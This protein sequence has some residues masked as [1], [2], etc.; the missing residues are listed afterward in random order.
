MALDIVGF[1]WGLTGSHYPESLVET[2]QHLAR[3]GYK[4]SSDQPLER[5]VTTMANEMLQVNDNKT[6]DV[7]AKK[8]SSSEADL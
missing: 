7:E 1:S 8:G 5:Q 2:M 3:L 4:R 6:A